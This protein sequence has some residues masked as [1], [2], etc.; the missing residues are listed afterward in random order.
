M[1]TQNNFFVDLLHF[2]KEVAVITADFDSEWVFD[3][4]RQHVAKN[5]PVLIKGGC[6]H[7]PAVQKW[8]TDY[9]R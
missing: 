3:F 2:Y 8:N 5:Q 6:L 1:I 4:H 9:L 7:F